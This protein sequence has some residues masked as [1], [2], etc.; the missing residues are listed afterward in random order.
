MKQSQSAL[1]G[2][3]AEVS[4]MSCLKQEDIG[5]ATAKRKVGTKLNLSRAEVKRELE[6][7]R[8]PSSLWY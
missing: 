8:T 2:F 3:G 4:P 5:D 6:L 7:Y 1:S